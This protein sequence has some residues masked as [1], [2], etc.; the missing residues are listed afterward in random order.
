MLTI[1]AQIERPARK[2]QAFVFLL[3]TPYRETAVSAQI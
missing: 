3:R 1:P 2:K